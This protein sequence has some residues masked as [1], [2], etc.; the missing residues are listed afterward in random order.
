M[1]EFQHA[2]KN[3]VDIAQKPRVYFTCHPADFEASFSKL[4]ADIF[5]THDPAIYYSENMCAPISEEEREAL[6]SR[7]SLVVVPVTLAL[8]TTPNRAMDEDIP[9]ALRKNIPILPIM[10]EGGIVTFYEHHLS[11]SQSNPSLS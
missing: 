11:R 5:N 3:R 10:M 6:L 1:I 4:C 7:S 9:Y 8:L 2:I